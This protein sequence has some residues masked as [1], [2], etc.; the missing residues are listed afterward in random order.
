[1]HLCLMKSNS[2][3]F[4][5]YCA[6]IMLGK[7]KWTMKRRFLNNHLIKTWY[8]YNAQSNALKKCIYRS[9]V[10][11]IMWQQTKE[12]FHLTS[13]TNLHWTF[14]NIIILRIKFPFWLRKV[15]VHFK[16]YFAFILSW[17]RIPKPKISLIWE[18]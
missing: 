15:K 2:Y 16:C 10:I 18:V 14:N 6:I 7:W 12:F 3:L 13:P 9:T 5:V 11:I 8:W 17:A 1:M 4:Y